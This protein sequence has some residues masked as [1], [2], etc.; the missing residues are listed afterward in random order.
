MTPRT[1]YSP[2]QQEAIKETLRGILSATRPEELILVEYCFRRGSGRNQNSEMLG[3][4]GGSEAKLVMPIV[5]D[6][7]TKLAGTVAEKFGEIWGSKLA[8]QVLSH[9]L[10]ESKLKAEYLAQLRDAVVVRLQE[11]GFP[12]EEAAQAGD[13]LVATFVARPVLLRQIAGRG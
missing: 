3:Y 9:K 10:A 2:S 12:F 13:A 5:L 11:G 4:G 1:V 7:L 8:N 6:V